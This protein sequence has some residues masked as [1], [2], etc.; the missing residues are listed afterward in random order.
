M[1]DLRDALCV[2]HQSLNPELCLLRDGLRPFY[3][4]QPPHKTAQTG[5]ELG[6]GSASASPFSLALCPRPFTYFFF[7]TW[8]QPIRRHSESASCEAKQAFWWVLYTL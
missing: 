5:L 6:D 4:E 3:S 1:K 8:A 7:C 2:W